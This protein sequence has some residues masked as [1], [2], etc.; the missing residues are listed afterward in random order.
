MNELTQ[1][2]AEL[3]LTRHNSI[4][5]LKA[6]QTKATDQELVYAVGLL[7]AGRKSKNTDEDASKMTLRAYVIALHGQPC[8]AAKNAV[9]AYLRNQVPGAAKTFVPSCD[10]L[11]A[12]VERQFLLA[13]R[14][15]IDPPATNQ[16]GSYFER[17]R[18]V[19]AKYAGSKVIHEGIS[20][21][22]H[23]QMMKRNELPNPHF[24]VAQL[25]VIFAGTPNLVQ[26]PRGVE[27][28]TYPSSLRN[29]GGTS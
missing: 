24:Y 21:A 28:E 1:P 16:R 3:V 23:Q 11:L 22:Q 5:E 26:E 19:R 10:E 4:A 6:S 29:A 13:V 27:K 9:Y 18:E 2:D 20:S 8:F 7:F 14:H 17:Q 25:G 15:R 12:E